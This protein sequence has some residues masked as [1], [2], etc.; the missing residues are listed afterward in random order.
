MDSSPR[1]TVELLEFQQY[2]GTE[3][4]TSPPRAC[5]VM[6]AGGRV[7]VHAAVAAMAGGTSSSLTVALT[8]EDSSDGESYAQVGSGP[9]ASGTIMF[10]DL[11]STLRGVVDYPHGRYLRIKLQL[12]GSNPTAWMVVRATV[13]PWEG[14]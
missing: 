4:F 13:K 9:F 8:A 5:A 10:T 6:G 3:E 14:A 11:P 2:A 1:T 12:G 7:I